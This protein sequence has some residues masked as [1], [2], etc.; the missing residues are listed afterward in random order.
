M[1]ESRVYR[2]GE[3]AEATGVTRRT[4]HYYVGRGLLPAPSGAGLGTTYDDEHYYRVLLIKKMQ[5]AYLPLDEIRARLTGLRLQ[6][7][8]AMLADEVELSPAAHMTV[9]EPEVRMSTRY[10]RVSL[11]ADVELHFP[12]EGPARSRELVERVLEFVQSISKEV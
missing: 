4:I 5:Q 9:A 2:I 6:E 10:E 8:Q 7:V 11:G 12:V 1:A 3:L